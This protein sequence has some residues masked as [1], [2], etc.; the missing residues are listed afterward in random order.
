MPIAIVVIWEPK[1]GRPAEIEALLLRMR[2][3][4]R[5]EPG[6]LA[7]DVHRT[8]DGRFVLYERYRDAAAI[9]AH[10]ATDHY[11]ELVLGRGLALVAERAITRCE[12]L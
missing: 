1:P 12:L 10:H 9:E 8:E 2:E 6:C 4:S 5:R 7:Y 11:R 3:H